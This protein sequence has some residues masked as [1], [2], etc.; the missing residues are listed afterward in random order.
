M[1]RKASSKKGRGDANEPGPLGD[2]A[3]LWELV[4]RVRGLAWILFLDA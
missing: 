1:G 3:R 2:G 4:M